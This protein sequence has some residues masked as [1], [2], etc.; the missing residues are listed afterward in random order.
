MRSEHPH[1]IEH[2]A[3]RMIACA[4]V[5]DCAAGRIT[6]SAGHTHTC[7][8]VE[9]FELNA[10]QLPLKIRSETMCNHVLQRVVLTCSYTHRG[11]VVYGAV[12]LPQVIQKKRQGQ[13]TAHPLEKSLEY[14]TLHC[15]RVYENIFFTH[16]RSYRFLISDLLDRGGGGCL[17][18]RWFP[19]P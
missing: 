1:T 12:N 2:V 14:H 5:T 7:P 16:R 11:R 6:F 13:N 4:Q 17:T 3:E 10:P 19:P 18:T 9:L 15:T 8:G